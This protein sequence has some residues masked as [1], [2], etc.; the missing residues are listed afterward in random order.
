MQS[1]FIVNLRIQLSLI[2]KYAKLETIMSDFS[3]FFL[4]LNSML[5]F[6]MWSSYF[7]LERVGRLIDYEELV[8][9][10]D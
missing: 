8:T 2:Q 9:F 10:I 4:L 5:T 3:L 6:L 7:P 1:I